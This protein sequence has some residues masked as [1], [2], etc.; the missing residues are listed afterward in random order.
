MSYRES[1]EPAPLNQKPARRRTQTARLKAGELEPFV[2]RAAARTR[3]EGF[4]G[5]VLELESAARAAED[6]LEGLAL[7]AVAHP[8]VV[9]PGAQDA[10]E[11]ERD[12][13]EDED[14]ERDA[15]HSDFRFLISDFRFSP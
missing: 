9:E 15:D 13:D 8:A 2:E 3:R 6:F 12:V 10:R 1:Y 5:Y 14:G 7:A 4:V 11:Q